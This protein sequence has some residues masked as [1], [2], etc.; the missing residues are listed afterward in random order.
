[1]ITL[2]SS[3]HNLTYA[4]GRTVLLPSLLGGWTPSAPPPAPAPRRLRPLRSKTPLSATPSRRAQLPLSTRALSACYNRRPTR[5]IRTNG[6]EL[7]ATAR[8]ARRLAVRPP[9]A[10]PPC[11]PATSPSRHL[12]SISAPEHAANPSTTT[13]SHLP[14]GRISTVAWNVVSNILRGFTD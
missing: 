13:D 6:R 2:E 4:G 8:R 1:M 12:L 10:T 5:A 3:L 11:L 9:S 14:S 7:T